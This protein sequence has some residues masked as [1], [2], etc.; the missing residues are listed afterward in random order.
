MTLAST[1][2]LSA[3]GRHGKND[4][5]AVRGKVLLAGVKEQLRL[6][7]EPGT[8]RL[9]VSRGCVLYLPFDRD[10]LF[11]V[12]KNSYA[13]DLS[14]KG[15]H[16]K[17]QGKPRSK[18]GRRKEGLAFGGTPD[19]VLLPSGRVKLGT[20]SITLALW[21][22]PDG[23]S[24]QSEAI[25]SKMERAGYGLDRSRSGRF[26]FSIYA[27]GAYRFVFSKDL[28]GDRE[29]SFVVGVW[30]GRSIRLYLDGKLQEERATPRGP[31]NSR[32]VAAVG[33][34]PYLDTKKSI[35]FFKGIVDEVA[36]FDRALSAEEVETLYLLGKRGQPLMHP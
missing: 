4:V 29:W 13:L 19:C 8:D 17:F 14:G 36:V 27:N 28:V 3:Q 6:L 20:Q 35:S 18:K 10:T 16:G 22:L 25:F 11:Q 2:L 15:S 1:P 32:V 12:D 30:D 24:R 34:N 33:C 5:V 31:R 21:T 23:R 9:K 26:S 7:P